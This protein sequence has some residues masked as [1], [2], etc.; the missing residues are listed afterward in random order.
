MYVTRN[1]RGVSPVIGVILM[2]AITVLLAATAAS[3]FLGFQEELGTGAPTVSIEHDF[4]VEE[5]SH[6]LDV[7]HTGG[8]TLSRESVRIVLHGADC[9]GSLRGTRFTP[10]GLGASETEIAAGWS[11]ELSKANVCA[12]G[13]LDLSEATVEVIWV[14]SE[15]ETSQRLWRWRASGG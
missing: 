4:S 8:D 1:E 3:M 9:A 13:R 7:R 12:S 15:G 10:A 11:V 2:I 5:G 6:V 14:G